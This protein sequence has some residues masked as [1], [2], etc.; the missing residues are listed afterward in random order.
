[1]FKYFFFLHSIRAKRRRNLISHF[2]E[3]GI[4][5]QIH[6]NTGRLP[7]HNLPLKSA[8]YVV[9]FLL[10]YS[11]ENALLLPGK[12]PG[13]SRSDLKLYPSSVSKRG[14]WRNYHSAASFDDNIHAVAYSTFCRARRI[15]NFDETMSDLC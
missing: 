1:M 13:Y 2:I 15:N 4:A 8:E 6:G 11:E 14:I 12:V 3:N 10:N 9:R 5:S 7:N